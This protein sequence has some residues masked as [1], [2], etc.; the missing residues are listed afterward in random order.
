M[1]AG[2]NDPSKASRKLPTST[3]S[4]CHGLTF[5]SKSQSSKRNYVTVRSLTTHVASVNSYHLPKEGYHDLQISCGLALMRGRD[6][7]RKD[8]SKVLDLAWPVVTL[9][10]AQPWGAYLINL[11][12]F[13]WSTIV[14]HP[15]GYS[16]SCHWVEAARCSR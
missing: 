5:L 11:D 6:S 10:Y 4:R 15:Q 3:Q 16:P 2:E 7:G 13:R 12:P 1:K 14:F 8:G 9:S